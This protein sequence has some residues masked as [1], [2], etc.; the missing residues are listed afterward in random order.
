MMYPYMTLADGTEIVHSHILE[1]DGE[2]AVEVHFERSKPYGF[3]MARCKLPTYEWIV[4][5]G[6]ADDEIAVFEQMCRNNAHTFFKYA[7]LGGLNIAKAV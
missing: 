4:R 3:D 5:E 2:K 1:K 6:Y 7:E